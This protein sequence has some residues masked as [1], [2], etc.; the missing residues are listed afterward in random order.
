MVLEVHFNFVPHLSGVARLLAG[1][2]LSHS[3]LNTARLDDFCTLGTRIPGGK[4][5]YGSWP[6]ASMLFHCW[7]VMCLWRHYRKLGW[8]ESFCPPSM[9]S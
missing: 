9:E 4:V 5:P 8:V 6:R 1:K 2:I 7:F 3:C